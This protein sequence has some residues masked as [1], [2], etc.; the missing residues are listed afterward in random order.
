MDRVAKIENSVLKF[1]QQV[2][3]QEY[4][5]RFAMLA[6][7]IAELKDIVLKLQSYTMEV[8]KMLMQERVQI[9]SDLGSE[10]DKPLFVMSSSEQ[11]TPNMTE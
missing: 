4:E 6:N 11:S 7:E 3:S 1:E 10:T 9:L 2:D 8:N 5:N